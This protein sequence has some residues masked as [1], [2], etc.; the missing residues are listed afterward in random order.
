M[1]LSCRIEA[2]TGDNQT[3]VNVETIRAEMAAERRKLD[4]ETRK[5]IVSIVLVAAARA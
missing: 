1:R 2:C 5:F 4:W 3:I